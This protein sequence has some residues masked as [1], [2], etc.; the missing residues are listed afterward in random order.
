MFSLLFTSCIDKS[1]KE[2]LKH[3]DT[4]SSVERD[5]IIS[6]KDR[7]EELDSINDYVNDKLPE[8]LVEHFP[9]LARI[10]KEQLL[11][12]KENTSLLV[13]IKQ[14]NTYGDTHDNI[15]NLI[16]ENN[17]SFSTVKESV[18]VEY[19]K[20][21]RS[22]DVEDIEYYSFDSTE[23]L[24]IGS[25][26]YGDFNGDGKYE[27]AFRILVK[28]GYGNPVEDGM[29]DEYEI[30]FSDTSIKSLNVNCCW[31]TLVNEGDLN[32]D[33]VDNIT[34]VQD[35]ENGCMGLVSTYTF[36]DNVGHKLF[37]P[38][39]V[40]ICD[41]IDVSTVESLV[42]KEDNVIYILKIDPDGGMPIKTKAVL[43]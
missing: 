31:F 30:K 28:K 15:L 25:K 16:I 6:P 22:I 36:K 5:N 29:P 34:I 42:T 2:T 23:Q 38:F 40:F 35:P 14:T 9:Q 24:T 32:N 21:K 33:G 39:F 7:K 12:N 13:A 11:S 41:G 1:N 37:D 19:F 3:F 27:Y 26:I 18:L 10:V 8:L 4:V 17:Y 43:Y 20:T